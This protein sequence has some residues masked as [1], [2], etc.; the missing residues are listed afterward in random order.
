MQAK[1]PDPPK[2]SPL[3]ETPKPDPENCIIVSGAKGIRVA[4]PLVITTLTA[5]A[6]TESKIIA[7]K[8]RTSWRYM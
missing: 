2:P 4:D 1:N 5:L 8:A 3:A 6:G 7:K